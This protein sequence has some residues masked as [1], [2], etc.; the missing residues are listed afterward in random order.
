MQ[1]LCVDTCSPL[2]QLV[3]LIYMPHAQNTHSEMN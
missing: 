1:E 2:I 3:L